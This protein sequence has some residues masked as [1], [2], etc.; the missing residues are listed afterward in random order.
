ME[1]EQRESE[2]KRWIGNMRLWW[3]PQ[4]YSHMSLHILYFLIYRYCFFKAIWKGDLKEEWEPQVS[5]GTNLFGF[6]LDY[7]PR[8]AILGKCGPLKFATQ[9]KI[10]SS[11]EIEKHNISHQIRGTG[12]TFSRGEVAHGPADG[13]WQ[14]WE[15]LVALCSL[16][17]WCFP[18]MSSHGLGKGAEQ[19]KIP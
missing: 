5:E 13:L 7:K 16:L 1:R 12:G 6:S 9:L 14:P 4:K 3:T 15:P 19:P 18:G 10:S 8:R 2:A 17:P 11:C